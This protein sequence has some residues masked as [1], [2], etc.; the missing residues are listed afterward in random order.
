MKAVSF[1]LKF[2]CWILIFLLFQQVG[3]Q[4]TLMDETFTMIVVFYHETPLVL[5]EL[6]RILRLLRPEM[7]KKVKYDLHKD[8][9]ISWWTFYFYKL[10]I[11]KIK[12][13]FWT[14]FNAIFT[15]ITLF[16][17]RFWFQTMLIDNDSIARIFDWFWHF[18]LKNPP[19]SKS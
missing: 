9:F 2:D 7:M 6:L 17:A 16:S 5:L 14:I 3:L 8:L 13:Y 15:K 18:Y 11:I 4:G 12:T 19:L 1:R 10:F